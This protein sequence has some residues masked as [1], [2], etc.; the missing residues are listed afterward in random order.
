MVDLSQPE[1][2]DHSRALMGVVTDSG[3]LEARIPFAGKRPPLQAMKSVA[4]GGAIPASV[5]PRLER[6]IGN[7]TSGL[8]LLGSERSVDNPAVELVTATLAM[9]EHC[10]PAARIM[11]RNRST[12]AKD[13]LVPASISDLPFLPSIESAY[14]QGYRR[15]IV[16]PNYTDGELLLEFADQVMLIAGVYGS[17]VDE[18]FVRG[19]RMNGRSSEADLL[20]FVIAVVGVKDTLPQA[21]P[22]YAVSDVFI[23][24]AGT[25]A[26]ASTGGDQIYDYLT[27][28]R[29]LRWED[30][31][32]ALIDA[33]KFTTE[34]ATELFGPSRKI[35]EFLA[36]RGVSIS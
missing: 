25:P 24:S 6:A 31:F 8:I 33:G 5:L 36:A 29:M 2:S 15:M 11:A 20:P 7:R 27:E 16:S 35:S 14:D 26:A 4:T 1:G 19:V 18:I 10:G 13:W 17:Q 34:L 22:T 21:V 23:P 30:E 12:P 28:H 3:E 9:T 32:T